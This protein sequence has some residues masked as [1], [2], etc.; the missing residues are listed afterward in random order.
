[1]TRGL[2]GNAGLTL[3][4]QR[5]AAVSI[6]SNLAEGSASPSDLD[7]ARFVA[8]A[9]GSA[10]QLSFQTRVGEPLGYLDHGAHIRLSNDV[11]RLRRQMR[12]LRSKLRSQG[13]PADG[14]PDHDAS[15]QAFIEAR[16]SPVVMS[17]VNGTWSS[18]T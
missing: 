1:M 2:P 10:A 8:I 6:G 16:L 7:F 15:D 11:D 14:R 4:S 17:T 12:S 18:A 3:T 5:R 13:P 9:D